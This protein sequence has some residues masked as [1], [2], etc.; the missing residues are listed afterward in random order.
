MISD[1][2]PQRLFHVVALGILLSYPIMAIKWVPLGGGARYLSVLAGPLSLVLLYLAPR[3]EIQPLLKAA[4]LWMLPFIPFVVVW[5]FAQVWHAYDPLDA[6]PLSRLLWCAALFVGARLAGVSYR[7]LAIV[8]GMGAIGYG[9]VALVEVYWLGRPRA[10]GGTYENRFG[11]YAIWLA[12]LCCLHV[13]FAKPDE[14][15]RGLKYFLLVASMFGF[16]ATILSGARGALL[17][18]FVIFFVILQHFADR[19]RAWLIV[20][21]LLAAVLSV[22]FFYPPINERLGMAIVEIREY[23]NTPEFRPTSLGERLELIHISLLMLIEHPLL[24]PGYTSIEQLFQT[25]PGLGVPPPELLGIAGFHNDWSQMIG[26]G[27]GVLL[28]ALA[29]T[30]VWLAVVARRDIYRQAFLGFALVF[31]LSEIFFSNKLGFSLLMVSWALYAAA[32]AN[33]KPTDESH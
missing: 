3:G 10:W 22:C 18:S 13:L 2:F 25:H 23:F 24:G 28:L 30:C 12:A 7:H 8:A 15:S 11:Q 1:R 14:N 32:G 4:W 26:I 29:A 17:A 21:S 31:G 19:K 9:L 5:M 16:L 27:G 20:G 33:Q 6:M